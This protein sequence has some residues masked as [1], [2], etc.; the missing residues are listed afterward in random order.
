M[1][2]YLSILRMHYSQNLS[3]R[4]IGASVGCGK[5]AVGRFIRAREP[6]KI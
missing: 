5:T 2:D 1:L 3:F 4:E 6:V